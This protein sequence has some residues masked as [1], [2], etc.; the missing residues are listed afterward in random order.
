MK[1]L[2]LF[3]AMWL[4]FLL[5]IPLVVCADTDMFHEPSGNEI[6]AE[7]AVT[8]ACQ[9]IKELTGVELTG[10]YS[11]EDGMK[12]EGQPE[13]YFGFGWQWCADTQEDCWILILR[14][15]TSIDKTIVL[16]HVITGEVLYWEYTQQTTNCTYLNSLP[17]DDHLSCEEA[18][19]NAK[20]KFMLAMDQPL[21]VDGIRITGAAFGNADTWV[22]QAANTDANL[23]WKI[24]LLYE[25]PDGQYGY[26]GFFDAKNGEVL[27]EFVNDRTTDPFSEPE[28]EE[29]LPEA[30]FAVPGAEDVSAEEIISSVRFAVGELGHY[31]QKDVEMMEMKAYFLYHERFSYGWEPVWLIY[32]YQENSLAFKA[33]Y[34]YDGTYIDLVEA[35]MEFANTI[36]N[37]CFSAAQGESF[38]DMNFWNMSIE[39]KAQFSEKWIPLVNAYLSQHP[40]A[41]YPNDLF[42]YATRCVYGIPAEDD[43][44]QEDAIHLARQATVTLGASLDTLDRRPVECLFDITDPQNPLWKIVVMSAKV[45]R[46]EYVTNQ[47]WARYRVVINAKTG[48]VEEAW[49]IQP[50]MDVILWRF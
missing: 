9:F 46:N 38:I 5:L 47:N 26:I 27:R 36:R 43:I 50:E 17:T 49:E 40:Y 22:A 33:L 8:L 42:Y 41:P 20:N 12:V 24:E 3:A 44:Q 16:L 23:A 19:E 31:S 45:N 10:L 2:S 28:N 18:V 30:V 13:M 7:E 1:R 39:E 11:V 32:I 25:A 14:N 21:S 15:Q 48:I 29:L 34:A 6:Q 37:G 4:C 35:G